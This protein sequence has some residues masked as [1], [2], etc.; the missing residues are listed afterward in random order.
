MSDM[1]I[2]YRKILDFL[3]TNE[4]RN[5]TDIEADC[6]RSFRITKD[7]LKKAMDEMSMWG[8]TVERTHRK[9][10]IRD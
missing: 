1:P 7:E 10:K 6:V 3:N 9:I 4:G 5:R 8:T 2:V